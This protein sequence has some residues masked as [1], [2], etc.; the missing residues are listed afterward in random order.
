M[1]YYNVTAHTLY[2]SCISSAWEWSGQDDPLT[3]A[4]AWVEAENI[5]EVWKLVQRWFELMENGGAD[6]RYPDPY[7]NDEDHPGKVTLTQDVAD[8][9]I[10]E[11]DADF[12]LEKN[13]FQG[14]LA[15][16]FIRLPAHARM[17]FVQDAY[18]VIKTSKQVEKEAKE[19]LDSGE[20]LPPPVS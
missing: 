16:E 15:P 8:T 3:R 6:H 7:W 1:P 18:K 2:Q 4:R 14:R 11:M 10:E 17:A 19:R 20:T 5:Y 12:M 9:F 13:R